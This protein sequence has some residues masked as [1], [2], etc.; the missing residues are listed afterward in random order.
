MQLNPKDILHG[1]RVE[2]AQELKEIGATLWRM[3]Y[4]KNGADLIWLEREDDNKTFAIAFKTI[5]S[6]DTGVFHILEHSVLCGSDKYP[7]KEPFVELIKSSMATFLNALTFSDKTMYPISSRNPQDYLNLIDVYMDA[8]LH[9]LSIADPHA[10][11]QEGW[12]YELDDPAGELVCNGVVYNEMK[13]AYASNDTVLES[14]M[15]HQLFPDVCYGWESGGHPDHITELTYENYL[16]NHHKYYHPSNARIILDGAI[17]LDAVLA[18][19]DSFLCEYDRLD[20]DAEIPYQTPVMPDERTAYYEIGAEENETNKAIL[21]KGWVFGDYTEKEKNLAFSVLSEVLASSNESPLPKALLDKGLAEDVYFRSEFGIQQLYA[22]LMI[23]NADPAKKDEIWSVVREELQKLATNGLDHSRLHNTLSRIEFST[24]EMAYDGMPRGLVFA[25]LSL[26]SW[27]YGG[28][29]AQNLCYDEMFASLRKKIDEG[30]F[31]TFLRDVLLDNPHCAKVCLLPSKTL[32]QEKIAAEQARLADIKSRLSDEEID[33]VMREFKTLRER[34]E[35]EDTPEQLATLPKLSLADIPV[36]RKKT[37]QNVKTVDGVTVLHQPL[38]TNGITYLNLYFSLEDIPMEELSRISFLSTLLGESATEHY[39]ALALQ[40]E[41]QGKFGHFSASV[42]TSAKRGQT[43]EATPRLAVKAALLESSKADAVG[44]LD[45][46]LNRS[47][48]SDEGFVYNLLRQFRIAFEQDVAMRGNTFAAMRA[49]A[50]NSAKGA[51]DEAVSGIS[52]L[53]YLKR[54]D[55]DF[56]TNGTAFCGSLNALLGKLF[57]RSRLTVSVTGAYDEDWLK[58][59][60]AILG[61]A[62]MGAKVSYEK[63]PV[64]H[65]GF[66]IPAEI[67][68]AAKSYNV[69][70]LGTDMKGYAKVAAQLLT[71][72]YMWNDIRVKGG[73]YGTS[74]R[75]NAGGDV[76][77]TTYRDPSPSR[78]LHSFDKA[79]QALRD[80]C[81]NNGDIEKYI[82]STIAAVEPLLTPKTEGEVAVGMYF[83]G[84]T[85]DDLQRERDEILGTTSEQLE[86]FSRVLDEVCAKSGIC[87]VGGK[88]TLDACGNALDCVEAL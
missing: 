66:L 69:N 61:D 44:L 27:L 19:L 9:P 25:I 43:D 76:N 26:E 57:T 35:A 82:I 38:E 1:F 21:A 48:L 7:T 45:E 58:Q 78:S 50:S 34:Q 72:D 36:E 12:H 42:T 56:E 23:R 11:R 75:A 53:R 3:T 86:A 59:I 68:F 71:F 85:N 8:V 20:I 17:D 39:S 83:T 24:R 5:P 67:G 16:A 10:F 88:N 28:D 2:Y 46:V 74:L 55:S 41:L 33:T 80:F 60:I 18:K 31:E 84:I 64:R 81:G 54:T 62:P 15:N 29:P 32:G 4:E 40:S 63:A 79:G 37:L 30:W 51:I 87:V 22:Y 47:D 13:G 6:D 52:M 73:A 70:A 49:A 77:L 14:E 65:E